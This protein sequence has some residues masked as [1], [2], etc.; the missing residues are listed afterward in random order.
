MADYLTAQDLLD[1]KVDAATLSDVV[2]SDETTEVTARLGEVYPSMA[3]AIYT[4]IQNGG[5]E[6]FLTQTALLASVP[7]VPK[8]AAKALDTKK[9]WYWNGS[10]WVDTGLSEL[11]LAKADATTKANTAKSEAITAAETDA[12]TKANAAQAAAISAAAS[13][14]TTKANAAQASAVATAATDA[15]SKANT[16]ESNA[17][18]YADANPFFKTQILANGANLDTLPSGNYIIPSDS[19]AAT[20]TGLPPAFAVPR[21]GYVFVMRESTTNYMRVTR[22]SFAGEGYERFGNGKAASD[23]T[24]AWGDYRDL[25]NPAHLTALDTAIKAWANA[26]PK[27]KS[28]SL[29]AGEDLNNLPEGVYFATNTVIASLLNFPFAEMT[30]PDVGAIIYCDRLESGAIPYQKVIRYTAVEGHI[31]E[32]DRIGN[33]GAIGS[34]FAWLAW[35]K[36]VSTKDIDVLSAAINQI[37]T[38][39]PDLNLFK[40]PGLTAAGAYLYE[41]TVADEGGYPTLTMDTSKLS[42]VFYDHD[43]DDKYFKVGATVVFIAEIFSDAIGSSGGDV[44]I[45]ALNAAGTILTTSSTVRGSI[46]NTWHSLRTEL[47]LPAGTAKVRTRF[48]RRTGNTVVKFRNPILGSNTVYGR[49]INPMA[50]APGVAATQ[51]YYVSKSGNDA[52]A[53]TVASPFLSISKALTAI[54]DGGTIEIGGGDYRETLT[55]AKAGH[56]WLRSKRGERARIFGSDQLVVTKTSGYT[57]VYQ[58]ALSAKPVGMGAPRG[59][60]VIFEWNTPSKLIADDDRHFLQRGRVYRLPYTEMFEAATK[61]DLDTVG[62]RGKWFWESGIIYFAATDGSDATAKRYEA[63]V[64]PVLAQSLGSI[65]LTRIDCYFSNSYG[66]DFQGIYTKREDCRVFGSYHDGFSDDA[67]FTESYRDESGGNGNDGFNGTV[68]DYANK[69]DEETRIEATY[70]DPYGHDNGDDGLSYHVRGGVTIFGGLF[71]YNTKADVVHVTGANCVCYN[72]VAQGTLNG[73][74]S[75]TA[76]LDSR[77]KTV[78]RCVGTRARKNTYSYRAADDSVLNCESAVAESPV[79]SGFGYYQTGTGSLNAKNCKYT[80]D[81]AKSKSGN[82]IVTNDSQL[83]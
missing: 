64:R 10:A 75:A 49:M 66:M 25:I 24:F 41:A 39:K 33:G 9:V 30:D 78:M 17:K 18:G 32:I 23:P 6:P 13:D 56:V 57:Q 40:N 70:F 14:A 11:D 16:A 46:I 68:T 67:N 76:S 4:I 54:G 63:R 38:T 53:G 79:T 52:N 65:H 71:E 12:T 50:A 29:V 28:R 21:R 45:Q 19:V 1:A 5:F 80:G 7:T 37:K 51:V 61:A 8:K 58:A 82:V 73:F 2:N 43:L 55:I 60:P 31:E 69:L 72:T 81:P 34:S 74:Y 27:F 3:K 26:N 15:T 20:L 59:L 47:L 83:A 36:K 44:T 35:K 42:S 22:D 48:I 62:G 77:I